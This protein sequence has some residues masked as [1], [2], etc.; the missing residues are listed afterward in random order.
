VSKVRADPLEAIRVAVVCPIDERLLLSVT[1]NRMSDSTDA[2]VALGYGRTSLRIP[3][4]AR[5]TPANSD[6]TIYG[7]RLGDARSAIG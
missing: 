6:G 3:M 7:R 2:V 5:N 1:A 4:I